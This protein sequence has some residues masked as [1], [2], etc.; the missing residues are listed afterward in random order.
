MS[1]PL[2]DNL[3]GIHAGK[4]TPFLKLLDGSVISHSEFLAMSAQI[5]HVLTQHGLAPGDR[6]AVQVSKSP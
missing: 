2:Y 1:N 6:V 3:F 4:R 5:A